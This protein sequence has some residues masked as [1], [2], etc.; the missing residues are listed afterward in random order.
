MSTVMEKEE[1]HKL[2]DRMPSSATWD[3][4][5]REIYVRE[6]TERGL[7]D[8]KAGRTKD[9]KEVRRKYG[10]PDGFKKTIDIHILE[11]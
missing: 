7:S 8:S 11:L 4:L 2:I 9:V 10:L 1:A 6:A 3:D 5:M